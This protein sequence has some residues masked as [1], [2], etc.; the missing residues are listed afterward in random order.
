MNIPN[1]KDQPEF[2]ESA[3]AADKC[4]KVDTQD[5]NKMAVGSEASLLLSYNPS[6]LLSRKP[7][8]D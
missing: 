3:T 4:T 5:P 2:A 1:F 6:L 7:I 8:I